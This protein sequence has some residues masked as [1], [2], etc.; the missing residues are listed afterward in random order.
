MEWSYH[1][2]FTVSCNITQCKL[3]DE[4]GKKTYKTIDFF[5]YSRKNQISTKIRRTHRFSGRIHC[6]S[7][8]LSLFKCYSFPLN[9]PVAYQL[10][11]LQFNKINRSHSSHLNHIIKRM[12][13]TPC[14]IFF[15]PFAIIIITPVCIS[16]I[17]L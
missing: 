5:V 4:I 7:Q 8:H 2:D 6:S 13:F 16:A 1:R 3:L 14:L 11:K 10:K 12:C 17:C 9:S 15:I